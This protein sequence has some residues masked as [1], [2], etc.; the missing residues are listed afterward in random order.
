MAPRLA[1]ALAPGGIAV[2]SGLLAR[3]ERAVLAAH[4]AQR[5]VLRRRFA[6]DGWHTLMMA[7]RSE[8]E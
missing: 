6:H 2:L 8:V 4:R 7:K 5:L 3:Q 1:G